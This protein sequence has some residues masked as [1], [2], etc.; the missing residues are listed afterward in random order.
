[1]EGVRR[2]SGN[3]LSL[4]WSGSF[5]GTLSED[6]LQSEKQPYDAD[7]ELQLRMAASIVGGAISIR[8]GDI[9]QFPAAPGT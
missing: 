6:L 7:K 9:G 4:L 3:R 8:F 2:A 1:M 5:I